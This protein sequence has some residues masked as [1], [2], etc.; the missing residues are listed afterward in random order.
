[1]NAM[2]ASLRLLALLGL[3]L[4]AFGGESRAEKRV[5]LVIGNATYENTVPLKNPRNDATAMS[6]ALQRLGFKVLLGVDLDDSSFRRLAREFAEKVEDAN[7]ALL[8]YAG[9]GLQVNG[10]NYLLPINAALKRELDLEFEAVPLDLVLT[11]MER[12]ERVN[13]VL[14]DACRNN[15][16][17]DNLARSMG[18]RSASLGRGLARVETGVG[19]YVGFST[20]PGN[21]ALDGEGRHSPFAAA[22]LGNIAKP[23]LDIETL[24]R[25]VR[26]EVIK[27]TDGKQVPWGNSSLIGR[28]FVFN[29]SASEQAAANTE[30]AKP[31]PTVG[32]TDQ[33]NVE[34]AFWN[35]IK[36]SNSPAMLEAYLAEYPN[37]RFAR[38]ADIMLENLTGREEANTPVKQET[39]IQPQKQAALE[40]PA[41]DPQRQIAVEAKGAETPEAAAPKA[42][43]QTD[44]ASPQ[45]Q[46]AVEPKETAPEEPA[47][48]S[49][50]AEEAGFFT[51]VKG[52]GDVKLIE[53]YLKRYPKGRFVKEAKALIEEIKAKQAAIAPPAKVE[54]PEEEPAPV[55][56]KKPVKATK[57]KKKPVVI[58]KR[59]PIKEKR[60]VVVIKE[61][62]PIA[63]PAPRRESCGWCTFG[64]SQTTFICG[65]EFESMR[66]ARRCN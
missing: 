38:L 24:M 60:K 33:T 47:S 35:S 1:M 36:D 5:A 22:L 41:P 27:S 21:V 66:N 3:F 62:K 2:M 43:E 61:P 49:P 11:Q 17:A 50:D 7:V 6:A 42:A 53:S 12:R 64:R 15:P 26:E 40:P 39:S 58:E 9:H 55:V 54:E 32:L 8:F 14:L 65:R 19:T 46:A 37:G 51:A 16:L 13:I 44:L 56:Q 59:K 34:I 20:Q 48:Q 4:L 31:A 63:T 30:T 18:T 28:G 25:Q 57:E 45:K 52:S 10:R 23:D 29:P